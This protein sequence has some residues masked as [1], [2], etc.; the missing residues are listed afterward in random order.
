MAEY[1]NLDQGARDSIIVTSPRIQAAI[2]LL[3]THFAKF[4][5]DSEQIPQV[6]AKSSR[7]SQVK[8][9]SPRVRSTRFRTAPSTSSASTSSDDE[10]DSS[11]HSETS[12]V[13]NIQSQLRSPTL[14][15]SKQNSSSTIRSFEPLELDFSGLDEAIFAITTISTSPSTHRDAAKVYK[16]SRA[17][18]R[19]VRL[20]KHNDLQVSWI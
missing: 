9:A 19:Q 17:Q 7:R 2:D 13:M 20:M 1:F 5:P 12:S 6:P 10:H 18:R 14:H 8:T 4:Q 3:H 16:E 15:H 11:R